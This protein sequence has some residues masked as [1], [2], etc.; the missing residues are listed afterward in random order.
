MKNIQI[1]TIITLFALFACKAQNVVPLD[2]SEPI[3][4]RNSGDYYK[5]TN[6]LFNTFEGTW[7]WEDPT[8]NSSLTIILKKET[9][10]NDVHGFNYDILIGEYQYIENG[11]ELA[12]TLSDINNPNIP[13]V[14]HK[15]A[16]EIILTKYNR[17]PC[18]ECGADER[19][20]R[21]SIEHDNYKGVWGELII[22]HFVYLGIEKLKV[23]VRDGAWLPDDYN[24]APEDIDIPFGEYILT[25]Q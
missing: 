8:T 1:I 6:N 12:N 19:R 24:N 13:T 9:N 5:D 21:L 25:K 2:S 7:L 23:I 15:I 3:Y 20:V 16:G 17:P 22:R 4:I 11:V 10:V 18:P 14:L